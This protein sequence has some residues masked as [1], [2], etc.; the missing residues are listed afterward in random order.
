[1]EEGSKVELLKLQ[2]ESQ[3]TTHISSLGILQKNNSNINCHTITI[4]GELTRNNIYV[5]LIGN[6]SECNLNGLSILNEKQVAD[7][8]NI[9][10]HNDH[11]LTFYK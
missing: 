7:N 11:V 2:T 9:V 6:G 10:E 8:H 5:N 4:G 1:M 3:K